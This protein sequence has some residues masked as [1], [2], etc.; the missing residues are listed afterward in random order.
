MPNTYQSGTSGTTGTTN[1]TGTQTTTPVDPTL[2]TQ[3]NLA[4]IPGL[5]NLT[6]L[7][8][9][10]NQQSQTRVNLGRISGEG[11]LETQSSQNIADA[12]AG[13][14]SGSTKALLGQQTAESGIG[15]GMASDAD[16]LRLLGQTSEGL[17]GTGQEW[18]TA[19]TSRN[20]AAA[21]YDPTTGL[22]TAAQGGSTTNTTNS[23][24][25]DQKSS[26]N[27]SGSSSSYESGG[28]GGGGG[29][30][31]P[32]TNQG[33]NSGLGDLLATLSGTGGTTA[34][35]VIA[36]TAGT[37]G[38]NQSDWGTNEFASLGL[39]DEEYNSLFGTPENT[40]TTDT[41]SYYDPFA[42]YGD[43]YGV[44]SGEGG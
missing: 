30:S 10:I 8:N 33:G 27:Q 42:A 21:T 16:Y 29:R 41:E 39:S 1:S 2:T 3:K 38:V 12:L 23:S 11:G 31:T 44:G 18:L 19:A 43:V 36:D 17:Q 35:S 22:L 9:A 15:T 26:S 7:I 24:T 6:N 14:V 5:S 13:K 34:N 37:S 4:N 25:T 28:G 32:V 40:T 20:P